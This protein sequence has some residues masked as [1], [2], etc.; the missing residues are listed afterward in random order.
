MSMAER[1]PPEIV[2][3]D[4]AHTLTSIVAHHPVRSILELGASS[5]E[6][7]TAQFVAGMERNT[8][9]KLY[10]LEAS[11]ERFALLQQRY[12]NHPRVICINAFS[13]PKSQWLTPDDI[14]RF[15]IEYGCGFGGH[16]IKGWLQEEIDYH[17]K[18]GIPD[19]GIEQALALNGGP[20][21]VVLIDSSL[22]T[23]QAELAAVSGATFIALDDIRSMK[24]GENRKTLATNQNYQL[25]ACGHDRFGW[26]VFKKL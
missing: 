21:D 1:I 18:S 11:V 15:V 26:A 5:G 7:S 17:S 22:F 3:D 8:E 25:F 23:G 24:N 16:Q 19:N 2:S 12:A 9:A 10:S 4:F 13:V 14:D 20:F 6:G